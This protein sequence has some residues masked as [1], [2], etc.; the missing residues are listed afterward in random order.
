M[1]GCVKL[2][3]K[4]TYGLVVTEALHTLCDQLRR[5]G[6]GRTII[7]DCTVYVGFAQARPN[8]GILGQVDDHAH[9]LMNLTKLCSLGTRPSHTEEEEGLVNLHTY[10]FEGLVLRL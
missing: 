9:L 10:K 1:N 8:K 6:D 2:Q 7:H 5:V 4:Q 3:S